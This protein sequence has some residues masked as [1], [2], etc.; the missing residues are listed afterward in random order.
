MRETNFLKENKDKWAKFEQILKSKKKDPEELSNLFTE[1]TDDL[2]YSRT[3]YPNRSVRIYLNNIAQKVFHSIYKTKRTKVSA[4]VN[5]WLYKLPM[6]MHAAKTECRIALAVFLLSVSLGVLSNT[7]DPE[8]PRVIL[9]DRYIDMTLANIE[10][11]DP[12]AV[13]KQMNE[14]DML[15][16]ITLNN[17]FVAVRTFVFGIFL[18]IGSIAILFYNGIMVGTFQFFF[19]EQ[20]LFRESFLTIWMHGTLEISAFI[21]A[22]AAGIVMGKGIIAPGTF[23]RLQSFRISAQKGLTIMAGII[24]ILVL[25]AFVESFVTRFTDLPDLLRLFFILFSLAFILGYFVWYPVRVGRR[26]ANNLFEEE[27][28]PAS[29]SVH[30]SLKKIKTN[31]EVFRETFL[32]YKSFIGKIF[33]KMVW[34]SLLYA[35][36]IVW[37]KPPEIWDFLFYNGWYSW[38]LV[39]F[40]NYSFQPLLALPNTLLLSFILV[41][42]M[43]YFSRFYTAGSLV[44]NKTNFREVIGFAKQY[45]LKSILIA[46]MINLLFFIPGDIGWLLFFTFLSVWLM[47]FVILV[48]ENKK[49]GKSLRT[50]LNLFLGKHFWRLFSLYLILMLLSFIFFLVLNSPILWMYFEVIQWNILEGVVDPYVVYMGFVCFIMLLGLTLTFPI[51]VIGTALQ[52]FNLREITSAHYLKQEIASFHPGYVANKS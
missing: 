42:V 8:F 15:L 27:K 32:V 47:W 52:Y 14:T 37:W 29:P 48:M 40:F 30:I 51:L 39:D 21:I 28:I 34:L 41:H 12:M 31:G 18:A 49:T 16:G 20:G 19:I 38:R 1:I 44:E 46:A 26:E 5:F 43:F 9:G 25:A 22:A 23:T 6:A 2:S 45:Y 7:I 36:L 24:P 11:G 35:L 33:P 4:F 13:Y 50:A 17:L 10:Q 3:F